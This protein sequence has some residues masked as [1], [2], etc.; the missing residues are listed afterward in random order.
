MCCGDPKASQDVSNVKSLVPA[1]LSC[2]LYHV[3]IPR[4]IIDLSSCRHIFRSI[5]LINAPKPDHASTFHSGHKVH[6]GIISKSDES[7]NG[8]GKMFLQL[9][10]PFQFPYS[11]LWLQSYQISSRR[12]TAMLQLCSLLSLSYSLDIAT[13]L[14][15]AGLIWT[16]LRFYFDPPARIYTNPPSS[17]PSFRSS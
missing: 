11:Y 12:F 14:V 1:L 5:A 17:A 2:S 7:K 4:L 6:V 15:G 13:F 3:V 8:S 9:S 10:Y 16:G